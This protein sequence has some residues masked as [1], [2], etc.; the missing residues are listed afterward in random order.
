VHTK[1]LGTERIPR[2]KKR[3]RLTPLPSSVTLRETSEYTRTKCTLGTLYK[4]APNNREGNKQHLTIRVNFNKLELHPTVSLYPSFVPNQGT[5][6]GLLGNKEMHALNGNTTKGIRKGYVPPISSP[7]IKS[8]WKVYFVNSNG[9]TSN[10]NST[11]LTKSAI[12]RD[13]VKTKN[14]DLLLV[15]ETHNQKL[16]NIG[17]TWHTVYS[18]PT[19]DR[20]HGTAVISRHPIKCHEKDWN[21][22]SATMGEGEEAI[23]Y[24]SAYF[25]NHEDETALVTKKLDKLLNKSKAHRIILAADFNS[26]E[27]LN[28]YDTGGTLAPSAH[29]RKRAL[30]IQELLD[31]WHLKDMWLSHKNPNREM[32]RAS[33]E[34]ITHWNHDHTR[35]VRIDRFYANFPIKGKMEVNTLHHPGSDHKGLLLTIAPKG[36]KDKSQETKNPPAPA[37][38]YSLPSVKALVNTTLE[39]LWEN[40]EQGTKI[41]FKKWDKAKKTIAKGAAHIWRNHVREQG[42]T[43][44]NINRRISR[45]TKQLANTHPLDPRRDKMQKMLESNK[46]LLIIVTADK[47]RAREEIS[48]AKWTRISGK[49]DKDF[50]ATPKVGK[51]KLYP[52]TIENVKGKPDFPRTDDPKVIL[53]NFLAYYEELYKEKGVHIPTLDTLI[54]KLNLN[55]NEDQAAVLEASIDPAEVKLAIVTA[56]D[57]KSPGSDTIPYECWKINPGTTANIV[58][59]VGNMVAET[60]DQ[61]NSWR[62]IVISAL[63]KVDDPYSTHLYRPIALLNTDY[64]TVMRCW[65]NRLGPIL[66]DKIGHHQRGFIPGRDGRENIINVQLV[67]DLMNARLEDGAIL[68]L[69]QE[70]AFDM[71]SFT[72]INRIFNKLQWPEPFC[73]TIK[74]TY[75]L[76]RMRAKVKVGGHISEGTCPINSGT[77]QGCPLSPLIYAVVADLYNMSI[78]TSKAYT[79]HK[80]N[81]NRSVRISAFAD[82]T[83]VHVGNKRDLAISRT[84]LRKYA[85]ATGGI[86]N[87]DKSEG[88]HL[89][90][91]ALLKVPLGIKPT[92]AV[93]YLGVIQGP[94]SKVRAKAREDRLA[95]VARRL[96]YWDSKLPSSPPTRVFVAKI[97]CLSVIWYHAAIETEWDEFL[98]DLEKLIYKFI[99]KGSPPKVA[100]DT[101]RWTKE[102]GGLNMWDLVDKVHAFRILWVLKYIKGNL[103]PILQ[104]TWEALTSLYQERAGTDIPLWESRMDHGGSIMEHVGS[105]FFAATQSA[106]AKV[107]RRNPKLK[108]GKWVY[109]SNAENEGNSPQDKLYEG[110]ARILKA[111]KVEDT[112][113]EAYWEDPNGGLD[114]T[115]IWHLIRKLCYNSKTHASPKDL[116]L[117]VADKDSNPLKI[118]LVDIDEEEEEPRMADPLSPTYVKRD[119]MSKLYNALQMRNKPTRRKP[120]KW[121]QMGLASLKDAH[122]AHSSSWAHAKVRGHMWLAINHALPVGDRMFG[123]HKTKC[124]HCEG[125]ETIKHA[126]YGCTLARKVWKAVKKEWDYRTGHNTRNNPPSIIKDLFEFGDT[127]TEVARATLAGITSYRLWA[128][129]C[130]MLYNKELAP[131]P[132]SIANS[133]WIEMDYAALGRVQHLNIKRKWWSDRKKATMVP[134]EVADQKLESIGAETHSALALLSYWALPLS[135]LEEF[136]SS[137]LLGNSGDKE[138]F[139]SLA[140]PLPTYNLTDGKWR[141]STSPKPQGTLA[142]SAV[143]R[144]LTESG[145]S[146]SE[147]GD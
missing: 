131:P 46:R 134:H 49:A 72:T 56:P 87:L 136:Q 95:R 112:S 93:E 108:P 127:S 11:S 36:A 48:R 132:T 37:R 128:T 35:G 138:G 34:H 91:W 28:S 53:D 81:A 100:R 26:T 96:D 106:W 121:E 22:A 59:A 141:L 30:I 114:D 145:S 44:R 124:P 15:A 27:T 80:I 113:V 120:N 65:A 18:T 68:Y 51:R 74:A 75:T 5:A 13:L 2:V 116:Y 125:I 85:V 97:M 50:L 7:A 104:D 61:P 17:K 63:N 64:K 62:D 105:K 66:A 20:R 21:I 94:N 54:K 139:L 33:M 147:S 39:T 109:Y 32:E 71:V 130:A 137:R 43:T 40:A 31:K 55:L 42:K 29:R 60:A 111:P 38:A 41:S 47:E 107:V 52:M 24:I 88:L 69:D 103:N 140:T 101:V 84:Y 77:R 70:K 86:T 9:L 4:H 79:G 10:V 135:H 119:T 12:L 133:I 23:T 143:T 144:T 25:P 78:I 102:F 14:L 1:A 118:G 73:N 8:T 98:P 126:L 76:N 67:M 142:A 45:T 57:N 146:A 6:F 89:G 117:V 122:K 123:K 3:A 58:A 19:D 92:E 83:A 129:R 115:V 82:D 90:R 16:P 110:R 99:W